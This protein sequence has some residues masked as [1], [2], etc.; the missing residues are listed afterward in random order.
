MEKV[1]SL[2]LVFIVELITMEASKFDKEKLIK[3]KSRF[4]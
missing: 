1:N 3:S 2:F 4:D